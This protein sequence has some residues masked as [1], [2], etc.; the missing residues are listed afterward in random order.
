MKEIYE[1]KIIENQKISDGIY[2]LMFN[3]PEIAKVAKPGQFL[4]IKVGLDDSKVLRRP[5]SICDIINDYVVI[6][7]QIKGD[8][9][10][11]LSRQSSGEILS[12]LGPLGNGFPLVKNKKVALV[13][14]GI[15]VFP[16]LFL[17]KA[18]TNSTIDTFLGFKN[19]SCMVLNDEF[20]KTSD[21]FCVSTDDGSGGKKG[22]VTDYLKDE[23]SKYDVVYACGPTPMLVNVQKICKEYNKKMY[24]SLE[25]RMGCG[26][27][28]CLVC[29][30]S[31]KTQDENGFTYK[32]VCN[33]GPIFD[34]DTV[35]FE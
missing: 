19:K 29:V 26:I 25:Q 18:L 27:G 1:L 11:L 21:N 3:S 31:I 24:L 34:G 13:G 4:S 30:C 5:I 33:D 12:V 15:G 10:K 6:I 35:I 8:G 14:G 23:I 2:K 20:S 9:T 16:L 28:A 17:Q 7:Y 32:K 22:Y